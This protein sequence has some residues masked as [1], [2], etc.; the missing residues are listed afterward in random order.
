MLDFNA[1]PFVETASR[2]CINLSEVSQHLKLIISAL[3][4]LQKPHHSSGLPTLSRSAI[5]VLACGRLLRL[6]FK[7]TVELV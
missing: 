3:G 2:R 7:D 6:L 5:F 4:M 1:A